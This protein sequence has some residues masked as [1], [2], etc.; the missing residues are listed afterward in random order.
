MS[1]YSTVISSAAL[2]LVAMLLLAVFHKVRVVRAR[3]ARFEP[4]IALT[5]WRRTHASAL[6]IAVG[7]CELTIAVILIL[8]P[9]VG[10]LMVAVMLLAYAIA[11]GS[12]PPEAPCNCFGSMLTVPHRSTA[13]A[14]NITLVLTS[15]LAASMILSGAVESPK[16]TETSVGIAIVLAAL[17]AAYDI[18]KHYPLDSGTLGRGR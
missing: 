1:V 3:K 15:L 14:R 11:L 7:L 6:L 9:P 4:L 18:Q 8:F 5:E 16:V 13:V 17:L 12:L 10:F 2:L